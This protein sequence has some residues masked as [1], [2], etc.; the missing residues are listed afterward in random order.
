MADAGVFTISLDLE[1]YWGVRD[2]RTMEDYGENIRGVRRATEAMLAAFAEFDVH[3]TWAAVGFL[4]FRDADDL[5]RHL[6]EVLPG[7]TN[8]A[9]SP[10]DY[11][12]G[13]G[14][15]SMEPSNSPRR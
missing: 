8:P 12:A 7:Y 2:K 4:F 14:G 9:L 13:G 5:R 6:P 10:Y 1:L 3:A 15:R 11:M